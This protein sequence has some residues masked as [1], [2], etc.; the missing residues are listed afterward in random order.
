MLVL[1]HLFRDESLAPP[2][3]GLF[4]SIPPACVVSALPSHLSPKCTS[5]EQCADAPL[6]NPAASDFLASHY[7]A[8]P[9]SPL[10][11][12]LLFPSH[13]NLPPTYFAIGGMDPWRDPGLLYEEKVREEGGKTRLDIFPG[14]V[15]GFWSFF[16]EANFAKEYREK[17]EEALEWLLEQST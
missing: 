2:I 12:P 6:F 3:T 15:H 5:W 16:P 8:D 10:R 1:S 4:I 11:S 13:K 9:S 17:S 7:K 14:L